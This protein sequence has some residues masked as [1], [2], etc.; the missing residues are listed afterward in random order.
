MKNYGITTID[1]NYLYPQVAASYLVV[2]ED[3]ALFVDNNTSNSVPI[4]INEL[5]ARGLGP[6][7][8]RWI[9]IT[10]LHLDHAGGTYALLDK[11]PNA[12]VVAHPD[13]RRH[14][15]KPDRLISGVKRVYGEKKF[16]ELY[17]TVSPVPGNKIHDAP[18]Q[19][20]INLKKRI[21]CFIHTRGHSRY[22]ISVMDPKSNG[23]FTGDAFGLAYPLFQRGK[24]N[25]IFPATAPPEFDYEEA[26]AGISRIVSTGAD[27]A[28][29]THFGPF[30]IKNGEQLLVSQLEKY[31]S[32]IDKTLP[33]NLEQ[34]KLQSIFEGEI[35]KYYSDALGKNGVN[36]SEAEE[37]LLKM[38]IRINSMG[39]AYYTW[40]KQ[41]K[42][43]T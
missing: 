12:M 2:E 8:V 19:G 41:N 15:V 11:C 9:I 37:R 16:A 24:Q 40:K 17:G 3:E 21:F 36:L 34:D 32:L 30:D 31:K 23:I 39:L 27:L 35:W 42:D 38:D 10:H 14:L 25:F 5:K 13:A 1:C 18:D 20:E 7:N 6:E 26:L 22:H 33:L 4:L 28:Y 29:L 43:K